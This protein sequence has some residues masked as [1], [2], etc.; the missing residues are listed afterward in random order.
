MAFRVNQRHITG[1]KVAIHLI[2]SG[3]LIWTFWL[4]VTDQLGGDPVEALIHFSGIGAFNLL[5]LTMLVSP[6]AKWLKQGAL[7]NVRRMLGIYVF[8]Y[9]L[10]HV[11]SYWLFDLLGDVNAFIE[12]IIERPY[13]TVGMTAFVLLLL[14]TITSP[15]AIR[16]KMKARWQ[17]L[18]NT[19]YLAVLLVGLH[20]IWSVKSEIIEPGIYIALSLLLLVAR[21]DKLKRMIRKR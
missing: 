17:S 18:H 4:G 1:L 20:F 12:D 8:V 21:W 2:A 13:I 9:A 6:L 19:I 15:M 14:L 7:L 3:L 10:A 11:L 16:R 5:L